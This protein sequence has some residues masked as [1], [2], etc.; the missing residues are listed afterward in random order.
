MIL[1]QHPASFY[2]SDDE[3]DPEDGRISPCTFRFWAEG[4][5]GDKE[6]DNLP[7]HHSVSIIPRIPASP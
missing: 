2:I 4:C 6:G 7:Q 1:T 5:S 3:G